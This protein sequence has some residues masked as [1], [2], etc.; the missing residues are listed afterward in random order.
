MADP[1]RF[2]RALKRVGVISAF[3]I[4]LIVAS[5]VLGLVDERSRGFHLLIYCWISF[6]FVMLTVTHEVRCPRC[7]QRFH[8]KGLDY[9]QLTRR[10]LHCGQE[11]YAKLEARPKSEES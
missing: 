1:W 11:K 5:V 7:G 8:A 10:C 9:W 3:F 4:F 2:H 6:V